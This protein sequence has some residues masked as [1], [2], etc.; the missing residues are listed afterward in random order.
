ML[1]E[2]N[3]IKW[4]VTQDKYLYIECFC[5]KENHYFDGMFEAETLGFTCKKTKKHYKLKIE[6]VEE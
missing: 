6:I 1:G 3:M 5:G 2:V 4:G